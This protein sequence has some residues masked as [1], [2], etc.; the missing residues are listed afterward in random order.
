[1]I[2]TLT[3]NPAI[4]HNVTVDRLAFEDRAYILDTSESAGGRGINASHVIRSFGGETM[5]IAVAGGKRA[6]RFEEYLSKDGVPLELVRIRNELRTNLT[7]T[8]QQ[9]LTVKLNERGPE[10]DA[11]EQQRIEKAVCAK[12]NNAQWLM[13]CGSF[14]PGVPADYAK[15]LVASARKRGVKVLLD[16]DGDPLIQGLE[17]GPTVVAPNQQE[18]E[19]LLSRALI[20]RNHF[21]DAVERMRGMGAESVILSLGSRGAIGIY[22]ENHVVE[23]VPP[24]VE[25][26]CPI[27]AGDALA[28]AAVWAL[29]S[30]RDFPDAVRWGVAAGTASA[31]LPG[32]S[33]ATLD[34]TKALYPQVE[35][36]SLR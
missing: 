10:I 29:A 31:R 36:R 11:A 35:L 12:L 19:R 16:T 6:K 1:M 22:G 17:A 26:V 21:T 15:R 25:A 34:Q 14:P 20:T 33:F 3:L 9:G 5:A 27:G 32:L 7:I 28:A 23:A 24:R 13:I 18:A 2:L 30:G 8:D 4:D